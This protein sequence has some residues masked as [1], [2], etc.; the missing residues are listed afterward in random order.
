MSGDVEIVQPQFILME[1]SDLVPG[2]V[3]HVYCAGGWAKMKCGGM[4]E[5]A[6]EKAFSTRPKVSLFSR[7]PLPQVPEVVIFGFDAEDFGG[8]RVEAGGSLVY[9]RASFISPA[10]PYFSDP[11]SHFLAQI[12]RYNELHS[13]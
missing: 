4:N 5:R 6:A 7:A 13:A 11:S 8:F 3:M 10:W 1:T 9:F 12:E 2:K